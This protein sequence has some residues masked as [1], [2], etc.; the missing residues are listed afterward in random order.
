MNIEEKQASL[1]NLS[2]QPNILSTRSLLQELNLT[3]NAYDNS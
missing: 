1:R 2:N 3:G